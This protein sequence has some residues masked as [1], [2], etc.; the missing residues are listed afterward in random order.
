M[1]M[2]AIHVHNPV[3]DYVLAVEERVAGQRAYS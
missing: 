2:A 1:R 3:K